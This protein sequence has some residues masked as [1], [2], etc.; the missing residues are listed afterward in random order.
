MF[1]VG[2][3]PGCMRDV[4]LCQDLQ[5]FPFKSPIGGMGGP[6]EREVDIPWDGWMCEF[7]CDPVFICSCIEGSNVISL[8]E[9]VVSDACKYKGSS[10]VNP[11]CAVQN[12]IILSV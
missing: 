12:G 10:A 2:Y 11:I 1:I 5:C 7:D 6:I 9:R 4:K 3:K 8:N